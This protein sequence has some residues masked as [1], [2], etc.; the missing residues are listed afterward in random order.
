MSDPAEFSVSAL[1]KKREQSEQSGF[2]DAHETQQERPFERDRNGSA[3]EAR[4]EPDWQYG[5]KERTTRPQWE[6]ETPRRALPFPEEESDA[7]TETSFRL[8]FD[9][10]RILDAIQKSWRWWIGTALALG[11]IGFLCGY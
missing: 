6:E 1:R 4:E 8:P 2:R 3:H 11:T 5:R 7:G 10:F 9:L